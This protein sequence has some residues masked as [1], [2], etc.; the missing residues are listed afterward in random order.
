MQRPSRG[1]RFRAIGWDDVEWKRVI[2]AML[3]VGDDYVLSHKHEDPVMSSEDGCEKCIAFLKPLIIK[4]P[5][6][7][8]W[9]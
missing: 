8:V 7:S 1:F 2:T 6:N 9:S 5:L 4:A 3:E